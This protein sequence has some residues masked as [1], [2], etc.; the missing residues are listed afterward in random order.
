MWGNYIKKQKKFKGNVFFSGTAQICQQ[1]FFGKKHSRLKAK[2]LPKY[3]NW[4][5][6]HCKDENTEKK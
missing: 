2:W 5:I 1:N 4:P 6:L 3:V